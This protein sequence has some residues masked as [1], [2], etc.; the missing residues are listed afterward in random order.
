VT[1]I[2]SRVDCPSFERAALEVLVEGPD[3]PG[4]TDT[5]VRRLF[6]GSTLTSGRHNRLRNWPRVVVRVD[7][8]PA[9]VATYIQTPFE[10]QIPDFTVKVPAAAG[11][12]GSK[13]EQRVLDA[14]LDAIELAALAGGCRR[15]VLIPSVAAADLERRGYVVVREGC[16]GAWMEKSL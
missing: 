6:P 5:D 12:A 2:V 7:D 3:V 1:A 9:G 11:S 8:T 4:L 15:V 13:L 10:M 14:L 16:A